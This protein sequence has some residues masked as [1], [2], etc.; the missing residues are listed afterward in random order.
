MIRYSF[1]SQSSPTT[2]GGHDA[3]T[4]VVEIHRRGNGGGITTDKIVLVS[5]VLTLSMS[6]L[7]SFVLA[8]RLPPFFPPPFVGAGIVDIGERVCVVL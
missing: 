7:L 8:P 3:V 5:T 4:I 1:L 2:I 6:L